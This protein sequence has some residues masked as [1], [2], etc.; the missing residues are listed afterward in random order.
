MLFQ[1]KNALTN[2]ER[3]FKLLEK[4]LA[5]ANSKDAEMSFKIDSQ[6]IRQ[7]SQHSLGD[8]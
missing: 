5:I 1:V 8:L 6:D 7:V 3:M 2:I 4:K